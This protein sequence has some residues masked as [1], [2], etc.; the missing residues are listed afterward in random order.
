MEAEAGE[1]KSH[2][3]RKSKGQ[4]LSLSGRTLHWVPS[5]CVTEG[6]LHKGQTNLASSR[7]SAFF[8][9]YLSSSYSDA[10]I[11]GKGQQQQAV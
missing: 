2:L 8:S 5:L 10:H 6:T 9:F 11:P 4:R 7:K 1:G 3:M